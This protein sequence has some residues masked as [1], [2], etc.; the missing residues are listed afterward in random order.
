MGSG[1]MGHHVSWRDK[2]SLSPAI[3]HTRLRQMV[4]TAGFAGKIGL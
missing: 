1:G 4:G 2:L 3:L